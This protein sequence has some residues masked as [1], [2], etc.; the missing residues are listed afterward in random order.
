MLT[1]RPVIFFCVSKY[2]KQN[3]IIQFQWLLMEKKTG[4]YLVGL[5]GNKM[6]LDKNTPEKEISYVP[7]AKT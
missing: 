7:I 5:Y 4:N 1:G 6:S 2:V 3:R